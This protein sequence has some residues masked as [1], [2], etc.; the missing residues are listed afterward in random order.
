MVKLIKTPITKGAPKKSI[1][2]K[3]KRGA[4]ITTPEKG[5][6]SRH[7]QSLG[8]DSVRGAA[9]TTARK[10]NL[11]ATSGPSDVKKYDRKIRDGGAARANRRSTGRPKQFNAEIEAE[12]TDAWDGDDTLIY[13]EVAKVVS[14]PRTTLHKYATK[15]LDF[16]MLGTTVRP[17][18]SD[19]NRA[20]RMEPSASTRMHHTRRCVRGLELS[21]MGM[22]FKSCE[23]RPP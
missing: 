14:F 3:S 16:R 7:Y 10:F 18:P 19:A 21:D 12:I 13:R 15:F 11:N 6:I 8:G 4:C 23:T 5:Q 9:S 1:N 2:V 22:P 20:E 17:M